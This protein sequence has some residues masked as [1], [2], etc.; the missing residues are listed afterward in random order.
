MNN[1]AA[2]G[3]ATQPILSVAPAVTGD[4]W[5]VAADWAYLRTEGLVRDVVVH[6]RGSTVE[7]VTVGQTRPDD[8]VYVP[9]ATL[10][11]GLLDS[12][13]HLSFS[14]DAD[15]IDHLKE[16]PS[17]MLALR[18][19]GN[20]QRALA[21]GVTTVVDCGGHAKVIL[22]LRDSSS[23]GLLALPRIVSCGAPITTTAGHCHWL[24]GIADSRADVI[25]RAREQIALGADFIKIMLNGGNMTAG[26]NP[27]ELQY[28]A[29]TM[30][31]LGNECRRLHRPLV[32]HVHSASAIEIAAR[33]GATV[34]AHGTCMRQDGTVGA[35][36]EIIETLVENA[37]FVDPTIMVGRSPAVTGRRTARGQLRHEM[38]P[39]FG[40][41]A[42]AGVRLLAGTDAGVPGIGHD[43]I[44]GSIISLVEEVGLSIEDALAGATHLVADAFDLDTRGTIES[45]ALADLVLIGGDLH[46]DLEYLADPVGVWRGGQF[47]AGNEVGASAWRNSPQVVQIQ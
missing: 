18:S 36:P 31:A 23:Q 44:S 30:E 46:D 26:T 17:E 5:S 10:L 21:S 24:G 14:G 32:A 27:V 20:A 45:G 37:V 25:R 8:A 22:A 9:G 43:S 38:L 39:S 28:E 3:L 4:A 33:A 7:S 1:P 29:E 2:N 19:A 16:D 42:G 12:H 41:M 6:V 15:V 34:V 13:Q 11:P 35:T 47:V 40:N